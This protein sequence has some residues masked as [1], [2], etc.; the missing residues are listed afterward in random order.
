M[1]LKVIYKKVRDKDCE[2]S[3]LVPIREDKRMYTLLNKLAKQKYKKFILMIANDSKEPYLKEKDFPKELNYVYYHSPNPK[4]STFEKLNFL[5]DN[6]KTPY[7]AITESDCEPSEN[8]L[9]E[10]VP[11]VKKE[12]CVIKGCEARPMS[13]C[14]ANLIMPSEVAKKEKFDTNIPIVGDYEWGMNIE[15]KGYK[16][17]ILSQ[18]GMVYHNLLTGKARFNRIIPC[19][20]DDVYMAI[21][22]KSP[23]FLWHKVLRNG[24]Q[25]LLGIS[26][27]ILYIWFIPY[28]FIKKTFHASS[29]KER[30]FLDDPRFKDESKKSMDI[31]KAISKS[32]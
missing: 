27:T 19:A 23:G 5:I 17:K 30:G 8:W 2:V 24:Y 14:T 7:L 12:N 10:L 1:D 21:K 20:Q 9:S 16:F 15:K 22:Y 6:V 3:V 32:R 29:N 31:K 26:Q 25:A 13:W 4:Y 18:E 28:L 11:L